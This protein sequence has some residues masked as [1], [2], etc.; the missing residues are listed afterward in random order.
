M[1]SP[2]RP[3]PFRGTLT[4][5]QIAQ[6]MNCAG[7]NAER[8]CA[9]AETMLAG[10]RWP[11]A[12]SL[13]VLSIEEA[14]KVAILRRFI[15]AT[16]EEIKGLW[17]EYRS[18]TK[19]NL[20][21]IF[22]ALVR[23]GAR[24]LEQFR[25]IVSPGSDHPEVLDF[26]KQLGLYTDCLGDAHWSIP[27]DVISEA[28]ATQLVGTTRVLLPKRAVTERELELWAKHM[29]PVWMT[30]MEWMKT[31][32]GNW[33]ADMQAQGLMPS[34]ANDME[35]FLGRGLTDAQ[36]KKLSDTPER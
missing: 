27:T 30:N 17:K 34:G 25:P 18:H 35:A 23:A 29:K 5:A 33:Y 6:G 21:W 28:L 26:I 32:L 9:D 10:K 14:G 15:T 24:T 12:T 16:P 13:A 36:S 3:S 20:N 7:E 8:L 19:K 22:P 2:S 1:E 31:A 11:T 4:L